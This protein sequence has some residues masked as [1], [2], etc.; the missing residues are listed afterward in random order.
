MS[1]KNRVL[2]LTTAVGYDPIHTYVFRDSLMKTGFNG[3][4]AILMDHYAQTAHKD[5]LTPDIDIISYTAPARTFKKRIGRDPLKKI[6]YYSYKF[7]NLIL[8]PLLYLAP[9]QAYRL[10]VYFNFIMLNRNIFYYQYLLEHQNSYDWVMLVDVRDALFQKNPVTSL[11]SEHGAISEVFVSGVETKATTLGGNVHNAFWVERTYN[12]K[13]LKEF[14]NRRVICARTMY[15]TTQTMISYLKNMCNEC[16]KVTSKLSGRRIG[17]DQAIHNILLYQNK[18]P[19]TVLT[20][21]FQSPLA[22]LHDESET[23]IMS[24][25]EN[26]VLKRQDNNEPVMLVHQYDRFPQLEKDLVARIK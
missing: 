17:S 11:P 26:G 24:L 6:K 9:N 20:E 7:L 21:N 8:L 14:G 19:H 2:I 25:V 13:I 15:G 5:V 1:Q 3:K 10:S 16:V 18:I 4:L 22:N 23:E 12:K